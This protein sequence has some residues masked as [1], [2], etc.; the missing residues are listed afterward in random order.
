MDISWLGNNN[1]L[2]TD[3]II[4]VVVNP[5]KNLDSIIFNETNQ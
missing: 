3:E 5:D 1:F 2:I 4:N